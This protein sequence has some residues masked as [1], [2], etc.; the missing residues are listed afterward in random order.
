MKSENLQ[1]RKFDVLLDAV[2]YQDWWARRGYEEAPKHPKLFYVVQDAEYG[3]VAAGGIVLT[4]NDYCFPDGFCTNPIAPPE[5]RDLALKKLAIWVLET[6]LEMGYKR[7][8]LITPVSRM[9]D[10]YKDAMAYGIMNGMGMEF[11]EFPAHKVY[12]ISAKRGQG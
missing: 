7:A 11:N 12:E 8:L 4:D 3:P 9:V 6:G 5:M 10:L 2:W 1:F